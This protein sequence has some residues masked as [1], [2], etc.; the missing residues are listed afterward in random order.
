L[1]RQCTSHG[2]ARAAG[3]GPRWRA[4][5][6][7]SGVHRLVAA[8]TG[9]APGCRAPAQRAC[10]QD[11]VEPL[12]RESSDL[13]PLALSGS[14]TP[15]SSLGL[16]AT[17]FRPFAPLPLPTPKVSESMRRGHGE[18]SRLHFARPGPAGQGRRV[19]RA[20]MRTD[21]GAPAAGREHGGRARR[22]PSQT[23]PGRV[24]RA[25]PAGGVGHLQ[26]A[27]RGRIRFRGAGGGRFVSSVF[28]DCRSLALV[29]PMIPET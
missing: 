16:F 5:P 8:R 4:R 18:R 14:P 10:G 13:S 2:P 6:C 23:G 29:Y 3:P 12:G 15:S 25:G 9:G 19:T 26:G 20:V 28:F 17:G 21:I 7:L 27:G 11:G 22:E 1:V 24:G